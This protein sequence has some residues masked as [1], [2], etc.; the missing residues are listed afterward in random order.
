[1]AERPGIRP[2]H[3]RQGVPKR[4]R[5]SAS[6]GGFVFHTGALNPTALTDGP[7]SSGNRHF[8]GVSASTGISRSVFRW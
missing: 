8:S 1:M 4:L 5:S 6:G 7:E 3:T 2:V